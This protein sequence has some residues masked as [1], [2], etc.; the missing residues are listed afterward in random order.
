M[1]APNSAFSE[2]Q[3]TLKLF[4]ELVTSEGKG[5]QLTKIVVAKKLH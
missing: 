4:D 2:L 3:S 5:K 1:Y